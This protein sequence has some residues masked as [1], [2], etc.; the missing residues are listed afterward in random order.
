ML[1]VVIGDEVDSYAEMAV[2]P[3]ASNA[4]QVSLGMFRKVK[5]DHH[6]HS[7]YVDAACE[8]IYNQQLKWAIVKKKWSMLWV[9]YFSVYL[10]KAVLYFTAL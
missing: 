4:V 2:T 7:L 10:L 5:V 8:Q 9:K 6:I 3:W 1:P